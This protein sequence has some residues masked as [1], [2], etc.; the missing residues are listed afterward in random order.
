MESSEHYLHTHLTTLAKSM[1]KQGYT[2]D[3]MPN[4]Q[5]I[6]PHQA[7]TKRFAKPPIME[8]FYR[9]M[10]KEHNILMEGDE[11]L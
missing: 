4:T 10:R 11:P 9:R 5:S 6:I 3:F 2:I 1:H 7:F 8:T